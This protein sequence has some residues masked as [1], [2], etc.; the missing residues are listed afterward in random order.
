MRN[1]SRFLTVLREI[2][3]VVV[4][5]IAVLTLVGVIGPATAQQFGFPFFEQP[6][7]RQRGNYGGGNG[8]FGGGNEAPYFAPFQQAPRRVVREDYSRAPAP[9]KR[10]DTATPPERNIVVLGDAMAD[11]LG[12]GLEDAYAEQP[13]I[14]VVRRHKTVSGL[15]RYQPK[16]DPADW[17]AAVKGV[18][19]PE[20]PA[21]VVIMLGLNDRVALREPAKSDKPADKKPADA[22]K[23][24]EAKPGPKPNERDA[25]LSDDPAEIAE[26]APII[27]PEK[28]VRS[29]NGSYE[30]RE[31]R[32]VELYTKKIEDMI[33]AAKTKG[34]PV[35]WVGLPAIRG[36]KATSD[37]LFLNAL[38]RDTA[39]KAGITFVDVW[40]GFVDES[41]RFMQQGPDFEGQ[42]R[43]LRSY[44]GVYFTKA[45][46]RKLAHYV[47]REINRLLATRS[48]PIALPTEPEKPDVEDK[49]GG[50]PPRPLAGPIVPLVVASVASDQLMGGP[51]SKPATVD[52]LV[53]RALVKGEPLAPPPGRADDGVWPRREV[54]RE[55]APK[56]GDMPALASATVDGVTPVMTTPAPEA[57]KKRKVRPIQP[58]QQAS[59]VGGFQDFFG[60]GG[61]S[62]QQPQRAPQPQ[63]A[64]Q[65]QQQPQP[66]Q[67]RAPPVFG[68]AAPGGWFAR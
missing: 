14:G 54:G 19:A 61:N 18:L 49:P 1:R 66:R 33:A 43:R 51:G 65:P 31:D 57:P 63:Y 47:D 5:A 68:L 52:A 41:G 34:V 59:P 12:F 8:W 16:G 35:I 58:Q 29:A 25:E 24:A 10:T 38:Y 26:P 39:Q 50:P 3:P 20:N 27:T 55:T 28:S 22:A 64:P 11:W 9:E 46:A 17:P 32:W 42:T 4:A 7:Q 2:A 15:I 23:P 45:G 37:M 44:D 56:G 6:Q 62:F 53:S 67:V 40:D 30:F 48:A 21:A 13:D 36:S 60:F